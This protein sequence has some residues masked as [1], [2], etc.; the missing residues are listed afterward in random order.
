[1]DNPK[2][3]EAFDWAQLNLE[4]VEQKARKIL[5][6]IPGDVK[7][8]LD[9][10]CGN[11]AITNVLN[12]KY[13][14]TAIDR[15]EKA[16]S[17]VKANKIVA[18]SDDIPFPDQSFDMVFSSE[19]LEHL[20]EETFQKTVEEFKRL[21][22]KYIFISVPNGEN[23]NKLAIK[24]PKCGYIYNRPNH[25][26]SI[27]KEDLVHLFDGFKLVYHEEFGPKTRYYRPALL[28]MKIKLTPS[29]SWIPKYWIPEAQR[30]TF[31]PSCEHQFVIPYRFNLLSFGIDVFNVMVSPKKPY[32]Q[33][34]LLEKK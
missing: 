23:P 20:E 26:R 18:S 27:K 11:G 21:T 16:L 24:C 31:C 4:K 15:S 12:T 9:V 6:I 19:L 33:F 3:Y 28:K 1:M 30:K 8:L 7:T 14:V 32:W 25:L 17:Y 10:G 2:L 13:D 5:N 22:K 34:A 29:D